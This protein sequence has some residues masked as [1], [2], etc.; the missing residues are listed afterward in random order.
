L[1]KI[2]SIGKGIQVPDSTKVFPLFN[3]RDFS[4]SLPGNLL[5]DFSLAVGEI[6]PGRQSKVHVMPLV[7]QV[8]LVLQGKLEVWMKDVDQLEPYSLRLGAEQAILT[9][10]GT[11]L[12][13]RNHTGLPCRALYIVS[14]AYL[15]VMEKGKVVYDDSVVLEEDWEE[16]EKIDWK[17][18]KLRSSDSIGKDRQ[19]A[20]ERFAGL[21]R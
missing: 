4:S 11:F 19:A 9:R 15:F 5:E 18:A 21:S 20:K 12:Q 2:F 17:P 16:L 1:R 10:P 7:T 6:E 8:T 13:F 14:P 3:C